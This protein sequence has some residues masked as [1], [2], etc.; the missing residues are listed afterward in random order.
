MVWASTVETCDVDTES[1][2]ETMA[3]HAALGDCGQKF[4][5]ECSQ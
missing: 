4:S 2:A 3:A 5:K 1:G